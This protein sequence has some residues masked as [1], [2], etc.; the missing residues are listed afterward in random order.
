M[1]KN[2]Q[3][4]IPSKAPRAYTL[5]LHERKVYRSLCVDY[6]ITS[7]LS[8][9]SSRMPSPLIALILLT[10]TLVIIDTVIQLFYKESW[11]FLSPFNAALKCLS[12]NDAN[13]YDYA[14]WRDFQATEKQIYFLLLTLSLLFD[15]NIVRNTCAS[16]EFCWF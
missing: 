4:T 1:V 16:F 6:S 10:V 3:P 13:C 7:F 2:L 15:G 14:E 12:S 5:S 11:E 8:F 9:N